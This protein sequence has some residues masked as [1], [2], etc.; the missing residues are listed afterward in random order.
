MV[1][2][3]GKSDSSSLKRKKDDV[4][5]AFTK[6]IEDLSS[7]SMKAGEEKSRQ[8]QKKAEI[9]KEIDELAKVEQ[10]SN[11]IVLKF[12]KLLK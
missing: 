9:Q 10:E 8:E 7:V 12:T 1:L 3:N 4:L 11:E 2:S 6:V 5:S